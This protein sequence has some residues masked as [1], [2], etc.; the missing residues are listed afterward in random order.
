MRL[1]AADAAA[2]GR[3]HR[4]RR[5]ELAGAA[6]A[7][8]RELAHDLVVGRIDVVGELDL[9]DGPQAVDR[10]ADRRGDDAAFRDRRIEHA[11]LA[12]FALQPVGDAEHAAEVADVLAEDDDRRIALEHDVHRRIQRL[13]HVHLRHGVISAA[14]LFA[15]FGCLAAQMLA[16]SP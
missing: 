10:H 9:G 8:A 3:A 5:V 13:D 12:V 2:A 11:V 15:R 4:H 16:A 7:D 14:H 6:I 1:A